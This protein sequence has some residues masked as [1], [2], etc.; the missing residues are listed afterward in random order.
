MSF[1]LVVVRKIEPNL[2][3]IFDNWLTLDRVAGAHSCSGLSLLIIV[4]KVKC[5]L[6]LLLLLLRIKLYWVPSP[7]PGLA[8]LIF[9]IAFW[10]LKGHTLASASLHITLLLLGHILPILALKSHPIIIRHSWLNFL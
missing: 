5:D 4:R 1:L 7:N 2:S 3:F 9:V 10:N 8:L 6:F